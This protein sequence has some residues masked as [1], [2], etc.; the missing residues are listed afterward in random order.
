MAILPPPAST[1][2]YRSVQGS[3]RYGRGVRPSPRPAYL[4]RK[5]R[6]SAANRTPGNHASA[7]PCASRFGGR[8]DD[9]DVRDG[10]SGIWY[11]M[12]RMWI[13]FSR[14]ISAQPID[15]GLRLSEHTTPILPVNPA[16]LRSGSAHA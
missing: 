14:M 11:R 8:I 15:K 3:D 7:K 4:M 5:V 12:K 2:C 9:P 10:V 6:T 13:A 16:G 1:A